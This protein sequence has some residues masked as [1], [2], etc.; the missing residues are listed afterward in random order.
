MLNKKKFDIEKTPNKLTEDNIKKPIE[1]NETNEFP[2]DGSHL[3]KL[4]TADEIEKE[5]KEEEIKYLENQLKVRLRDFE[6]IQNI[7]KEK[8]KEFFQSTVNPSN[9]GRRFNDRITV[10]DCIIENNK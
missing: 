10:Y 9:D 2:N 1:K 7:D 8:Q 3:P 4:Q 5:R 6:T